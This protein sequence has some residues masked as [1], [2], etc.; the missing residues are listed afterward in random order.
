[1][2]GRDAGWHEREREKKE[3]GVWKRGEVG[4]Q[5]KSHKRKKLATANRRRRWTTED[6]LGKAYQTEV[7]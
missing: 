3:A 5:L 4:V 6:R 2:K 1:M 7:D